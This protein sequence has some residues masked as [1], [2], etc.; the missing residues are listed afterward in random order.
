MQSR[1]V[2]AYAVLA[3]TAAAIFAMTAENLT[4]FGRDVLNLSDRLAYLVPVTL[5]GAAFATG[6]VVTALAATG[7]AAVLPRLMSLGFVTASAAFAW[8]EAEHFGGGNVAATY[9]A[10]MSVALWLVW[11]RAVQS[12]RKVT[13]KAQRKASAPSF[14]VLRWIRFPRETWQAWSLGLK[15]DVTDPAEALALLWQGEQIRRLD[16][17][18]ELPADMSNADALRLALDVTDG[19]VPSALRWLKARGRSVDRSQAYKVAN[20]AANGGRKGVTAR[21]EAGSAD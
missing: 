21:V 9:F 5:D 16:E 4:R 14:P 3:L 12:V 20:S 15:H 10:G 18:N 2:L 13:M 8:Y 7:K 17:A 11:D 19:D 1:M 6:I